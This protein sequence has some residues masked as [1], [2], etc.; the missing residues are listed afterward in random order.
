MLNDFYKLIKKLRIEQDLSQLEVADKIGL[1][2]TTYISF[3]QGRAELKL[4]EA[5]KLSDIFG[6]SLDDIKSNLKPN[7]LKYKNMILAYLRE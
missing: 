3:E 6:I 5:I 7:S 4:A 2:R 1:G